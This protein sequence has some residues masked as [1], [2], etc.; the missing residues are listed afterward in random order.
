MVYSSFALFLISH[1][2]ADELQQDDDEEEEL[3]DESDSESSLSAF[4]AASPFFTMRRRV[5]S[6]LKEQ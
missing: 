1:S 6:V 4:F 5:N 3:E 2:D